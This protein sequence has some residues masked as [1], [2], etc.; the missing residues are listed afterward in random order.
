MD[1]GFFRCL[2][3]EFSPELAGRRLMKAYDPAPDV[4]ALELAPGGRG[5]YLLLRWRGRSPALFLADSK[6]A[7]AS[8]PAAR[9]MWLRKRVS[10]RR[11]L[12]VAAHWPGRILALTLSP[13]PEFPGLDVL[14]LDLRAGVSLVPALPEGFGLEPEWP[15]LGRIL[16]DAEVWRDCPHVGPALRRT[17]AALPEAEAAALLGRVAAGKCPCFY[18]Y[19][20]EALAWPLPEALAGERR[21]LRFAC[22]LDAAEAAG[23]AMLF[24]YLEAAARTAQDQ[25]AKAEAKRLRRALE[26]LDRD[27]ERLAG[28]AGLAESGERLKAVL[29][30]HGSSAR[31]ARVAAPLPG[32]GEGMVELDVR[33]TLAGNM[34]R[35]FRLAAKGRRGLVHLA[36]RREELARR[37]EELAA[38]AAPLRPDPRAGDRERPRAKAAPPAK[39]EPF[40]RFRTTDGLAVLRG[41]NARANHALLGRVAGHDLWLHAAH[42]PSAHV[43]LRRDHPGVEA[44]ESSLAQAAALCANKSAGAADSRVEVM[45][46]EVRHVRKVKGLAPGTVR[47]DKVWRVISVSPD[48]GLEAE[49]SDES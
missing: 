34:E 28:L 49:L 47:V 19:G 35:F 6:P 8:P 27:A 25:A 15:D 11:I 48:P 5:R 29:G 31:L 42:G 37:L 39:A 17:L 38:G 20:N 45:V 12:A 23:Q 36:A 2:A 9:T 1:A 32:G 44:P 7:A 4:L 46:A 3:R 16:A 26:R 21:P 40:A 14:L 43:V 10:G 22:A 41:K 24:P 33:L 13:A 30:A 18:V